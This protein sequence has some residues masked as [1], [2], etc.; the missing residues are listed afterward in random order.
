M[1]LPLSRLH[2]VRGERSNVPRVIARL[3]TKRRKTAKRAIIG[4]KTLKKRIIDKKCNLN[5]RNSLILQDNK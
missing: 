3:F 5:E 1:V 4:G 2:H